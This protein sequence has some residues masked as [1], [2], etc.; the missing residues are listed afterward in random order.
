MIEVRIN[1]IRRS[2]MM[3]LVMVSTDFGNSRSSSSISS[4][5]SPSSSS[6]PSGGRRVGRNSNR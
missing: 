1:V 5:S 4:S 6:N 3:V 2:V